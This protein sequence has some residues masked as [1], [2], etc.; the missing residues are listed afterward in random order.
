MNILVMANFKAEASGNFINSL[1]ALGKAVQELSWEMIYLFPLKDDG[2]EC[3]WMD[4]IR[5]HGFKVLSL[6]ENTP[7]NEQ[8]QYVLQ[9][10]DENSIDLIH[11]HFSCMNPLLL[12][13]REIHQKVKILYHDHMDY[14]PDKPIPEQIKK[15]IKT[16][17]RYREY[18]LGVISVMKK[19][20]RGYFL[21]PKRWYIPNGITYQR[22][23]ER[24]KS[25]EEMRALLQIKDDERLCLFLGWDIYRKGLDIAIRAVQEARARGHNIIL[26]VVG[27]GSEPCEE[28]C[29]RIKSVIGFDPFVEGVRF[30]DS[31]EDMFALHRASD[32]FLS[33]S[34]TEAFAYAI[35]EAISQNVPVAVSD[36]S[37]TKWSLR[38]SKSVKFHSGNIH[39]C[40]DAIIKAAAMRDE[41]S[42]HEEITQKY[43]IDIWTQRVINVYRS[44]VKEG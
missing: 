14:L 31:E 7:A 19:K 36:I 30:L 40:A 12:W 2:S 9:I 25:R 44:M 32:V 39:Q 43:N 34:R 26:G 38:Y 23:V 3:G 24:S 37:G 6:N 17:K 4:Y 29:E 22:N 33:A 1:I 11:T 18:G 27:F 21:A 41:P 10:I 28:Y 16:A 5:A 35:L 13:D 20:H 42:N 8:K 15:Q